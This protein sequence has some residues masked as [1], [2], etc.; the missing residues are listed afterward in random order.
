MG[1]ST[2]KPGHAHIYSVNEFPF[3]FVHILKCFYYV[4]AYPDRKVMDTQLL[5][6]HAS[7]WRVPLDKSSC[8]FI[9]PLMA[10]WFSNGS[11]GFVK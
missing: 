2:W 8:G 3:I 6:T 9:K 11:D 7:M 5:Q 10:K 1:G 4:N